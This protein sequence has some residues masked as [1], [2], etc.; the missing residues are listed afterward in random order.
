MPTRQDVQ[1]LVRAHAA[2]DDPMETAIWIRQEATE[3]CLVEVLPSMAEDDHPER[4]TL[5]N[6]GISFRFPLR[7][8]AGNRED[9]ERAIHSDLQLARDIAHGDVLYGDE[10]GAELKALAAR[11]SNGNGR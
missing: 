5:F 7:L 1:E 8:W 4:P 11:I 2:L 10:T 6:P 3:A 9:I